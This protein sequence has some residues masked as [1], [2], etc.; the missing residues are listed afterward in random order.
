MDAAAMAGEA[1]RTTG[2]RRTRA[3]PA[4]ADARAAEPDAFGV[5][6]GRRNQKA[7]QSSVDDAEGRACSHHPRRLTA[8]SHLDGGQRCAERSDAAS[9]FVLRQ[10]PSRGWK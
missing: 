3:E 10:G 4:S 1:G 5:T 8:S 9:L 7:A 6:D 2:C